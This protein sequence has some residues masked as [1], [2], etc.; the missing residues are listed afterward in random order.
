M[1][2]FA[3]TPEKHRKISEQQG[4]CVIVYAVLAFRGARFSLPKTTEG[5]ENPVDEAVTANTGDM[6]E[7]A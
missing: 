1:L 7:A 5:N 4:C 3:K 2:H 6:A